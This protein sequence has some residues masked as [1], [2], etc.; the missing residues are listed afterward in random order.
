M[1]Y[2]LHHHLTKYDRS[3]FLILKPIS[4][5]FG[6]VFLCRNYWSSLDLMASIWETAISILPGNLNSD[7]SYL[8]TAVP[9]D[10]YAKPWLS[11]YTQSKYTTTLDH[12]WA[13]KWQ[14]FLLLICPLPLT[15]NALSKLRRLTNKWRHS[16][17]LKRRGKVV[18]T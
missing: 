13:K 16:F 4:Y 10:F 1:E 5:F 8:I 6:I 7:R 2:I 12:N 3:V 15:K 9:I 11:L 17:Q 14:D 18:I